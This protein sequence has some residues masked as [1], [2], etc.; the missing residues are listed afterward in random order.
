M[1]E[2]EL[3]KGP[4]FV[5]EDEQLTAIVEIMGEKRWDSLAKASGTLE[6]LN[7]YI[8]LNNFGKT[9][10]CFLVYSFLCLLR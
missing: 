5:E 4:W 7:T 2:E 8:S 10:N 1:Q 3:R 9:H 6:M